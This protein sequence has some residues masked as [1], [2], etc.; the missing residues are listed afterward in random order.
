MDDRSARPHDQKP[1]N[2]AEDLPHGGDVRA[3]ARPGRSP[4]IT[5]YVLRELFRPF[6]FFIVVLTGVIWLAQ[7]LRVVDTVVASGQAAVVFLEFSVLLMPRVMGLVLPL[8]AFGAALYTINRLFAESEIVAMIAAGMSGVALARPI[9]LFGGTVAAIAAVSSLWLEPNASTA[10]RDRLSDIRNDI[11]GALIVE[12][13]FLHPAEGLTIFVRRNLGDDGMRGV[14][15]HD[16]R[17]GDGVTYTAREAVLTAGEDGPRLVMLDG[18]AQR[19]EPGGGLSLLRFQSLV[20]DLGRFIDTA[21]DRRRAPSERYF[22]EL[23]APTDEQLE[24]FARGRFVAEGHEQLSAPLYALTLPL[25]ATAGILG[26]GF[27]RRGYGPRIAAALAA[28]AGL[29]LLGFL[30]KSATTAN[31]A[32][33]PLMYAPPVLGA[34]AAL[35]VL[36]RGAL[37]R[38]RRPPK[39]AEV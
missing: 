39:I 17:D 29:R 9:A 3:D 30:L 33:W 15:V 1:S 37:L 24:G 28:G 31:P 21:R 4:R 13:R 20:Y 10:F 38:R 7:S 2:P 22:F 8:A 34:L 19:V 18:A 26:A 6:V 14:F 32:L 23:V 35:W 36:D 16:R 12:G 27:S 25:V 11:A 5:R